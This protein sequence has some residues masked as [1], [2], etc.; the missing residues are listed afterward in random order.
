VAEQAALE[1]LSA[2]TK[3]CWLPAAVP[4]AAALR[5]SSPP[6]A[7]SPSQPAATS[8]GTAAPAAG[9]IATSSEGKRQQ[10]QKR[11]HDGEL[12]NAAAA[13]AA[14]AD[15]RELQNLSFAAPGSRQAVAPSRVGR[16][17]ADSLEVQL[18]EDDRPLQWPNTRRREMAS[19]DTLPPVDA[20]DLPPIG[21][22][23]SADWGAAFGVVKGRVTRRDPARSLVWLTYD[24]EDREYI[25]PVDWRRKAQVAP[26]G[27]AP[28]SG[29]PV[30]EPPAA[31]AAVSAAVAEPPAAAAPPAA[32][33]APAK[34]AFAGA[35]M[36]ATGAAAAAAAAASAATSAAQGGP[37][38][39]LQ[40]VF[41][42]L[43]PP[44]SDYCQEGSG[45]AAGASAA[46]RHRS[47]IPAAGRRIPDL[48]PGKFSAV[49][50]QELLQVHDVIDT[51]FRKVMTRGDL[52]RLGFTCRDMRALVAQLLAPTGPLGIKS[53]LGL[54]AT[55]FGRENA[56]RLYPHQHRSLRVMQA[57]EDPPGWRFGQMRGGLLADDPGLGKTVTMLALI[58]HS[59]GTLPQTPSEF[60]DRRAIEADWPEA[61]G[62]SLLA[63]NVLR[64]LVNPLA[65][66]SEEMADTS[67]IYRGNSV[68]H[69]ETYASFENAV[70]RS[71]RAAVARCA[72]CPGLSREARFTLV[73]QVKEASRRGMNAIRAGLDKRGRSFMCS[74]VGKRALFER[75][76][77]PAA[78][79]LVIVPG[80][81]LEHWVEQFGRHVDLSA[82]SRLAKGRT[83][84][85]GSAQSDGGLDAVPSERGAVWI[86]G[87]GDMADVRG[88]FPFP[89]A[90]TP[91]EQDSV[92]GRFGEAAEG[93]RLAMGW[94]DSGLEYVLA[95][96]SV[97]LTTYERCAYEHQRLH[98]GRLNAVAS[99]R[100]AE[101]PLMK[102]RWLRLMCDEGHELAT[103]DKSRNREES[104]AVQASLFISEIPAERRWVMSGT[105]TV[106]DRDLQGLEQ[107]GRLLSFLRHPRFG[108]SNGQEWKKHVLKRFKQAQKKGKVDPAAMAALKDLIVST[109]APLMVRHTKKD[110]ALPAPIEEKV[111]DGVVEKIQSTGPDNETC[112]TCLN[113]QLLKKGATCQAG[114]D[115]HCANRATC[116][117]HFN[118]ACRWV[119]YGEAS[120]T[121]RT[122]EGVAAHIMDIMGPARAAYSE[123]KKRA[124]RGGASGG[125]LSMG[126]GD[127]R[128]PKAVVFS[129]FTNDLDLVA[130]K[131][132][133]LTGEEG[134]ARHWGDYRSS[135][136]SIFRNGLYSYR[137]CPRCG[138]KN[139]SEVKADCCDRRLVEVLLAR[140]GG[141]GQAWSQNLNFTEQRE[142]LWPTETERIWVRE[143]YAGV[144]P[145]RQAGTHWQDTS[146]PHGRWWRLFEPGSDFR[147]ALEDLPYEMRDVWIQVDRPVE[148]TLPAPEWPEDNQNAV[149]STGV[150]C[151]VSPPG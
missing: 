75:C 67:E 138:Y 28:V 87:L 26:D 105:P 59:A 37:L 124:N 32:T 8:H 88:I 143:E 126:G 10:R 73:R 97:V 108:Q 133:G 13:A 27:W 86:D 93:G 12:A 40:A 48:G 149:S 95:N 42:E 136:L 139:N 100:Y 96:Y 123:R 11:R 115:Q 49:F 54:F 142:R 55:G 94:K 14:A 74:P 46:V 130:D 127:L 113:G 6:A 3:C 56:C 98:S 78:T 79:T 29:W 4:P 117:M 30:A 92:K 1:R 140:H 45:D 145:P 106:G 112:V 150:F 62:N 22:T 84:I 76:I 110:V 36:G 137:V 116:H 57:A 120:W 71:V 128:P 85:D 65:R 91:E 35:K 72:R 151:F 15:S 107:M 38:D 63:Q 50:L 121:R 102:L 135:S 39:L 146:D 60:L 52:M 25:D 31:A 23:L 111:W 7:S 89:R 18:D 68:Q 2:A 44:D 141:G 131:L 47:I 82:I 16:E 41:K 122:T 144:P 43:R 83:D 81:L 64:E 19:E 104:A 51:A 129:E 33:A 21:Q 77:L 58:T 34:Y 118:G 24:G 99:D 132:I 20:E 125:L 147:T 90:K 80:A 109:L 69:H 53:P 66:A 61:R 5:S 103:V 114:C 134:V 9:A 148:S 17:M 70:A 119:Y 101:S